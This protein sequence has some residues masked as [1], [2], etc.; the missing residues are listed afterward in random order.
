MADQ[1]QCGPR[2]LSAWYVKVCMT[3]I[4]KLINNNDTLQFLII[5]RICLGDVLVC[6]TVHAF[7]M[8]YEKTDLT[9]RA[10]IYNYLCPRT[11]YR[12]TESINVSFLPLKN[13]KT[14]F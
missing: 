11:S 3:A 14:L 10:L 4:T 12:P 2:D 6:L 8:R 9:A 5:V 13:D 7:L 1:Y